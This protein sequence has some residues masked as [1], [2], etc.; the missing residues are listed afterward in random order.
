MTGRGLLVA[1]ALTAAVTGACRRGADRAAAR[2]QAYRANNRG[3]AELEQFNYGEAADAFRQA[4][5]LDDS[6]A[7]THINLGLALLYSQDEAGAAREATVAARLLPAA[8]QPHYILGLAARAQNRPSEALREFERVRQI[9]PRDVGTEVNLGQIYLEQQQ[10]SQA[11]AVLRAAAA[12]EP[13]NVTAA[14]NLGLA[15][16]RS[17]QTTAGT[18]ALRH[19]QALRTTGYAVTLGTGYLE[20]GRYAEALASTGAEPDLVD[21]AVPA[22]RFTPVVVRAP[23]PSARPPSPFGRRFSADDLTSTGLQQIAAGLGGR[24]GTKDGDGL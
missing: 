23:Q 18:E 2:E 6:L 1:A 8:P 24:G 10:Y 19:A 13:F 14:Y 21:R 9:D 16:T 12:A 11:I 20:Q 22:V 17:G 15:L 3:V 4:L 7:I 5:H